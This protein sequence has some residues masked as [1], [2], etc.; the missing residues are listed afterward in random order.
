M[1]VT[2]ADL[3]QRYSL[4]SLMCPGP[5]FDNWIYAQPRPKPETGRDNPDKDAAVVGHD[6]PARASTTP[7]HPIG[8]S[9]YALTVPAEWKRPPAYWRNAT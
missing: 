9:H 8:T 7:R 5:D 2:K 1:R 4:L 6:K 3:N